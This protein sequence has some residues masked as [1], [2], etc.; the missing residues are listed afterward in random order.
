MPSESQ[1][2]CSGSGAQTGDVRTVNSRTSLPAVGNVALKAPPGLSSRS[3]PASPRGPPR[4]HFLDQ[5]KVAKDGAA[6]GFHSSNTP[7]AAR[8]RASLSLPRESDKE[9]P[10]SPP[11]PRAGRQPSSGGCRP[12]PPAVRGGVRASTGPR[13]ERVLPKALGQGGGRQPSPPAVRGGIWASAT[14]WLGC[15]K[16]AYPGA[17]KAAWN[18]CE[19]SGGPGCRAPRE[20]R[21]LAELPTALPGGERR[22]GTVHETSGGPSRSPPAQPVALEGSRALPGQSLATFF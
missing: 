3:G 9:R 22:L 11:G 8:P 14:P 4:R 16:S 5:K 15:R 1:V 12:G 2:I 21:R 17:Q 7:V 10:G 13:V 20:A 19:S 18:R 6:L